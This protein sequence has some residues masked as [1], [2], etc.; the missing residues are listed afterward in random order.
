LRCKGFFATPEHI[1]KAIDA[2]KNHEKVKIVRIKNR[3]K[4]L[5]D[6]MVNYWYG[7]TVIA[8]A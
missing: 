5:G 2:L 4:A 1:F 3:I 6:V 7:D 8:E